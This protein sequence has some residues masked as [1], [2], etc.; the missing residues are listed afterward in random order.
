MESFGLDAFPWEETDSFEEDGDSVIVNGYNELTAK[1]AQGL[2]IRLNH[3]VTQIEYTDRDITI[4]TSNGETFTGSAAVVTLP[5]GV[6][7]KD[8]VK[9]KPNLPFEKISV[10]SRLD[11]GNLNRFWLIFDKPFWNLSQFVYGLALNSSTEK[12]VLFY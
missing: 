5:L 12:M 10:I 1:L 6:L 9:F 8:Y 11:V 4:R 2:D 3:I 7:K